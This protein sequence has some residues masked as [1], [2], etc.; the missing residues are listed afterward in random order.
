[1]GNCGERRHSMFLVSLQ[2]HPTQHWRDIDI[3]LQFYCQFTM[4]K[5]ELEYRELEYRDCFTVFPV[6]FS[7]RLTSR[8]V[9]SIYLVVR[10]SRA[11]LVNSHARTCIPMPRK[12]KIISHTPNPDKPIDNN[13]KVH[14]RRCTIISTHPEPVA[15]TANSRSGP[16][17]EVGNIDNTTP[18]TR[19]KTATTAIPILNLPV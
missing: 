9:S 2:H 17:P 7:F 10:G 11:G 1:M 6:Q 18:K 5:I 4:M 19:Y 13:S 3:L 16:G 15:P 12:K 14:L 8:W